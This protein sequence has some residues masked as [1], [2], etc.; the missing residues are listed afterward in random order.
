MASLVAGLA[1]RGVAAGVNA[2]IA[3]SNASNAVN[4][5]D[6]RAQV[7]ARTLAAVG[8]VETAPAL[9]VDGMFKHGMAAVK[10]NLLFT[11]DTKCPS[12]NGGP[13]YSRKLK[14][15]PVMTQTWHLYIT[16]AGNWA[17]SPSVKRPPR[18]QFP[19]DTRLLE[20]A[21]V[22][23]G[24]ANWKSGLGSNKSLTVT[25]P[26][27]PELT[28]GMVGAMADDDSDGEEEPA[29]V[30]ALLPGA[31]ASGGGGGPVASTQPGGAVMRCPQSHP[32]TSEQ[33]GRCDVC[34]KDGTAFRCA[35]GCDYDVCA[36]CAA[37][38]APA[39]AAAPAV[40]PLRTVLLRKKTTGFGMVVSNAAEVLSLTNEPDGAPGPAQEAGITVG[41][42]VCEIN[43][44]TVSNK[45]E[46][47]TQVYGAGEAVFGYLPPLLLPAACATCGVALA[48]G[49]PFC[50]SCGART[51]PAGQAT[52]AASRP[53]LGA[54]DSC[55]EELQTGM[56]F[57]SGCGVA[58]PREAAEPK[59]GRNC[60][61]A[62][63]GPPP[64]EPLAAVAAATAAPAPFGDG[65]DTPAA[66]ITSE[67]QLIEDFLSDSKL[68]AH[69]VAFINGPE[70]AQRTV[71]ADIF[72]ITKDELVQMGLKP[73]ETKRCLRMVLQRF[74]VETGLE[75]YTAA[76]K[77]RDVKAVT[78][79]VGLEMHELLQMGM[80]TEEAKRV[81]SMASLLKMNGDGGHDNAASLMSP[82]E[83]EA[84]LVKVEKADAARNRVGKEEA[85]RAELTG[86]K[87]SELKKKARAEDSISEDDVDGV[88]DEDDP[89]A[90]V[91]ELLVKAAVA[92]HETG[93]CHQMAAS[94]VEAS[95]D[96][97]D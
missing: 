17:I 25:D 29:M 63:T 15:N 62:A 54:C 92:K 40:A 16:S 89:K 27:H 91:V 20:T 55:G 10:G 12:Y 6:D 75:A 37:A 82:E 93:E 77:A 1:A 48:P 78:D 14:F 70:D 28:K 95:A 64:V 11:L 71:V 72:H 4:N 53:V 50:T 23:R 68:S 19:G 58:V 35:G 33:G 80:K 45:Q 34:G 36:G 5:I 32:L 43:G 52:P 86:L 46:L 96:L 60:D 24:T 9:L 18:W 26:E 67:S 44:V 42:R 2:G 8:P 7:R 90:A 39:C 59:A 83:E 57:C 47:L 85:L 88:D 30:T 66:A 61:G 41:V 73:M 81:R 38:A 13:H 97:E 49:K 84:A 65:G 56:K 51:A 87:L 76:C 94:A 3:H 74:L 21:A 79:V 69:Q 22:P 31:Q